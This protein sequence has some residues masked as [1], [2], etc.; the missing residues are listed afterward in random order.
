MVEKVN[1]AHPDKVADRIG[2]ALVD[3][4]YKKSINPKIAVEVLIGH[5]ICHI[6]AETSVKFTKAEVKQVVHRIAGKMK[7]DFVQVPQ[8]VH[9]AGNQN[10]KIR[11]G[12]NGIFKGMPLTEEQKRLSKIVRELYNKYPSD[13]KYVLNGQRLIACQSN[14]NSKHLEYEINLFKSFSSTKCSVS[15]KIVSNLIFFTLFI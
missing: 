3:L 7:V 5:G 13:G 15:Y 11:C 8:D 9:L 6:I 10:E 4:A 2:G 14:A 1:A 12:D